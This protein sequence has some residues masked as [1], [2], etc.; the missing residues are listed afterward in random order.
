MI[1]FTLMTLF[2]I[3]RSTRRVIHP[4]NNDVT[5][6]RTSTI[7]QNHQHEQRVK[8][9]TQ[10]VRLSILQV[11]IF[12]VLNSVWTAYPLVNFISE[13]SGYFIFGGDLDGIVTFLGN[14]GMNLIYVYASVKGNYRCHS[15]RLIFSSLGDIFSLHISFEY[16]PK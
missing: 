1:V 5:S 15:H 4:E 16:I 2:N 8:R 13:K 3:R 7:L 10:L 6:R 12:V 11:L 14:F 9:D